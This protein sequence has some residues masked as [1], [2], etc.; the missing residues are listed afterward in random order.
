M[1][2]KF[3]FINCKQCNK[4]VVTNTHNKV[5]CSTR[6]ES[7]W[8]YTKRIPKLGS[9]NC[10]NCGKE[11]KKTQHNQVCCTRQCSQYKLKR[12]KPQ[13]EVATCVYCGQIFA[14]NAPNQKACSERCAN[15]HWYTT[16]HP[17]VEKAPILHKCEF[18]D[19]EFAKLNP[20]QKF[21]SEEC[22]KKS[23]Y[24][25]IVGYKE[26]EQRA[27]LF[28][29]KEFLTKIKNQKFC[30]ESCRGKS[31]G[32]YLEKPR[33]CVICGKQL[34]YKKNVSMQKYCK[35]CFVEE[36]KRR[37]QTVRSK[38][39]KVLTKEC[40]W[41]K[42]IFTAN[43]PI[44]K[45]CSSDCFDE[46]RHI[47]NITRLRKPSNKNTKRYKTPDERTL[48]YER[49]SA[50]LRN[51][52]KAKNVKK[53][54]ATQYLID[55]TIDQL[56][57]RLLSTLGE[58]WCWD[59]YISGKLQMDHIIPDSWFRYTSVEEIEFKRCWG[60]S[61]FQL[62]PKGQNASKSDRYMGKPRNSHLT[63]CSLEKVPVLLIPNNS[64]LTISTNNDFY[65]G[66]P[67]DFGVYSER[68]AYSIVPF[69]ADSE[70]QRLNQAIAYLESCTIRC[71]ENLHP[72]INNNILALAINSLKTTGQVDITKRHWHIKYLRDELV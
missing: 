19:G 9:A 48:M 42:Q 49:L 59:D 62:V 51:H 26:P 40:A 60:L 5:F 33:S 24:Q 21:C 32:L 13:S 58:G 23:S 17:K 38:A 2:S 71:C 7:A 55:F 66:L 67:E 4:E 41:C 20:R 43:L 29:S 69:A 47:Y 44:Q 68:L 12:K 57:E 45:F 46:N 25:R 16:S 52:L 15:R 64:F 50:C 54:N 3:G 34:E 37:K 72:F 39:K 35:A 36:A 10:K 11:F 70:D 31:K 63:A 30:S 8:W 14:K 22:S 6:C 28:C 1:Q 18:C 61:N 56:K 53:T 27:C 65:L